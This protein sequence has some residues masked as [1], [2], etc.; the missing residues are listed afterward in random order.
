MLSSQAC[1][2]AI[3]EPVC[4]DQGLSWLSLSSLCCRSTN[5]G[6]LLIRQAYCINSAQHNTELE[7]VQNNPP[8]PCLLAKR[9]PSGQMFGS[10]STPFQMMEASTHTGWRYPA[11]IVTECCQ[12]LTHWH[13]QYLNSLASSTTHTHSCWQHCIVA[14]PVKIYD[15]N[16]VIKLGMLLCIAMIVSFSSVTNSIIMINIPA[17]YYLVT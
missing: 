7:L 8:H 6:G 3:R 14:I 9:K 5:P 10:S 12:Q 1:S 17:M 11:V 2:L 13:L 16:T 15:P 4:C